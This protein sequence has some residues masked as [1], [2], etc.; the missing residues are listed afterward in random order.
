MITLAD[1][2]GYNTVTTL[3]NVDAIYIK[4]TEGVYRGRRRHC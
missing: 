1:V 3:A 2:S 4:A